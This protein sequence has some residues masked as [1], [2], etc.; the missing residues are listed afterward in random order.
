MLL[1]EMSLLNAEVDL[2]ESIL[3]NGVDPIPVYQA[4]NPDPPNLPPP[5]GNARARVITQPEHTAIPG[6]LGARSA[7][8]TARGSSSSSPTSPGPCNFSPRRWPGT[9]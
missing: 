7:R 8:G 4:F 9:T 1:L 2:F 5:S 6:I 3:A